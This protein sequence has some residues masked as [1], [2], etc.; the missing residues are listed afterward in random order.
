MFINMKFYFTLLL[1]L[2]F[3]KA[4]AQQAIL[5]I[6]NNIEPISGAI[7]IIEGKKYIAN[8]S[9]KVLLDL[10]FKSYNML[11]KAIGHKPLQTQIS[12]S[13]KVLT[14]SLNP[15]KREL[16]LVTVSGS[17]FKKRAAEEITSIEIIKP[18]FIK[19][20]G[21]NRVDEALNK[22]AGVD[23]LENQIN[24]RGGAGWS[25]GAGSRVAIM[26]DDMPMLTADAADAKWDFL[27]IE[28]AEQIE[29]L[30]GA[31]SVLYGSGALNG[32][33]NFRTAFAKNKPFTKI[34]LLGGQFFNPPN[35]EM[36]W[37]KGA[38]PGFGG[39]YFTHGRKIK[40]FDIVV[41][42]AYYK[43]NSYLQGDLTHRIRFNTNVK[44]N[45]LQKNG[46]KVG[47]NINAQTSDGQT[48][49]LHEADTSLK[50][51]LKPYGGLDSTST[52]NKNKGVRFNIDPYFTFTGKKGTTHNLRTRIFAAQ[53]NVANN[54]QS[55][56]AINYY[57]EY[58]ALK[59]WNDPKFKL[60]QNFNCIGG[61]LV[62]HNVVQ[63]ELYGNHT[64]NNMA[65]YGQVEKKIS[66]AWLVAGLR[67]E[68]N[69][70]DGAN[71]EGR[72]VARVGTNIEPFT[73]TNIRAS[74]GQGYRYPTIAEKFVNT[75]F[76]A[77][78]VFPNTQLIREK[79]NSL[80]LGIKQVFLFKKWLGVID[81]AYFDA[82]YFDMMEFNFLYLKPT[83]PNADSSILKNLGF[84]SLNIGDTR[85]NGIDLSIN[86]SN[87]GKYIQNISFGYLY[88]NPKF[89]NPSD[90]A[91]QNL[92]T[93]ENF[94]KYRYAHSFKLSY[95][96]ALGKFNL[97]TI[98][99]LVSPMKNIDAVFD[100][101]TANKNF[102]T[103]FFEFGTQGLPSTIAKYRSLFNKWN[104]IGDLRASY[105]ITHN[106][107]GAIV[108]KNINNTQYYQRPAIIGAPRNLTAQIFIDF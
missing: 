24:I 17:R 62:L 57:A 3:F 59:K 68:L 107:K 26:V 19:N 81:I 103:T 51:L 65:L 31:A 104:W 106:V 6:N 90:F 18:N 64:S 56:K 52:I 54:N 50:N 14:I 46:I 69:N 2:I 86:A 72:T 96:I 22:I 77:A 79:A 10:P 37:W 80:E 35:K 9:G 25:Y 33:V 74:W 27:P 45:G 82:K 4:N 1:A 93:S 89:V 99:T 20:A 63:G 66:I 92:S 78:K 21:I 53:N 44:Y 88:I 102:N 71:F 58:Q 30:K 70:T 98:N 73:G 7:I 47:L 67:H 76:G 55:S 39:F 97:G 108:L 29:V 95:D 36:I 60:L 83:D 101:S 100:I 43:E 85:I 16:A 105:Q 11:V 40:S 5:Y 49:F 75:S 87:K 15:L 38:N 28:N 23:V 48:F 91:L 61:A 8:D 12:I 42:S 34:Q 13:E 32:V 41:G 94:L 84:R